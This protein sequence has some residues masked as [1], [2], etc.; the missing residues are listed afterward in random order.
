MGVSNT[1]YVGWVKGLDQTLIE[2]E[3]VFRKY[4]FSY[5]II[6]LDPCANFENAKISK[7]RTSKPLGR[8]S[9]HPPLAQIYVKNVLWPRKCQNVLPVHVVIPW[10][11]G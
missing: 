3:S 6:F 10:Y 5:V 11:S 7:I 8:T 2:T 4:N 1:K 9:K